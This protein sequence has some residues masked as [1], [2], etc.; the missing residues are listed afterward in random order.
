MNGSDVA[1]PLFARS[2][3]K[4]RQA[5]SPAQ[6][7]AGSPRVGGVTWRAVGLMLAVSC[8]C[9]WGGAATP[10]LGQ[11]DA[12]SGTASAPSPDEAAI[13]YVRDLYRYELL[14]WKHKEGLPNETDKWSAVKV[15]DASWSVSFKAPA[16]NRRAAINAVWLISLPFDREPTPDEIKH[17]DDSHEQPL[18]PDARRLSQ[19]PTLPPTTGRYVRIIGSIVGLPPMHMSSISVGIAGYADLPTTALDL[20]GRD[21]EVA[22]GVVLQKA[23]PRQRLIQIRINPNATFAVANEYGEHSKAV[24]RKGFLSQLRK[25]PSAWAFFRFASGAHRTKSL[26]KTLRLKANRVVLLRDVVH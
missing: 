12:L 1:L 24:S 6:L 20:A 9:A 14:A 8:L 23:D 3:S 2:S 22:R 4:A 10:A 16:T 11:A 26:T 13:T 5:R 15:K 17:L 7:A 25:H 19:F 21:P 18:T